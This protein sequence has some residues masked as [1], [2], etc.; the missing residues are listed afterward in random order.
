MYIIVLFRKIKSILVTILRSLTNQSSTTLHSYF[1]SYQTLKNMLLYKWYSIGYSPENTMELGHP[2]FFHRKKGPERAE[3]CH[4]PPL[5]G[6]G[7]AAINGRVVDA[8]PKQCDGSD[9]SEA[10]GD[11]CDAEGWKIPLVSY[12]NDIVNHSKPD[13]IHIYNI[14]WYQ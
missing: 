9:G 6:S 13:F 2:L 8:S 4:V 14:L 11:C 7:Q 5:L 12:R 1:I 10:A 3:S